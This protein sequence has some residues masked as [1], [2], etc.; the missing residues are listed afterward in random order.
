MWIR[1]SKRG[2]R[3]VIN[4][5]NA[6]NIHL[7]TRWD[8]RLVNNVTVPKELQSPRYPG[9][10]GHTRAEFEHL[11]LDINEDGYE[12]LH[13]RVYPWAGQIMD[14]INDGLRYKSPG[15]DVSY[16]IM[17]EEHIRIWDRME[18]EVAESDA[19][20][21]KKKRYPKELYKLYCHSSQAE[22]LPD[23]T[24]NDRQQEQ[25]SDREME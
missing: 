15:I 5:A 18:E 9:L 22:Q 14:S 16:M 13:L 3:D 1:L 8:E 12:P 24:K 25:N 20:Y 10:K 11:Y 6:D 19:E 4:V 2:S 21:G 17:T 7:V 23:E